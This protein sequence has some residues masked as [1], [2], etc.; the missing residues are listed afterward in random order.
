MGFTTRKT[1]DE[2]REGQRLEE[3]HQRGW[4]EGREA[5]REELHQERNQTAI[6]EGQLGLRVD[7]LEAALRVA[8][9]M[10]LELRWTMPPCW[11]DCARALLDAGL[12]KGRPVVHDAARHDPEIGSAGWTARL[13]PHLNGCLLTATLNHD[14]WEIVAYSGEIVSAR[15][16]DLREA[17]QTARGMLEA[18]E[19]GG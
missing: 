13:L 8:L 9:R 7:E 15:S 12:P 11:L 6:R 17:L 18:M 19:E 4:D 1:E 14:R 5:L 2:D 10:S 16:P 3:A